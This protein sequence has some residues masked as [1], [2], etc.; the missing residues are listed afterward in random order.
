MPTRYTFRALLSIVV[1]LSTLSAGRGSPE[2]DPRAI[3][4]A[5]RIQKYVDDETLAGAVMAVSEGEKILAL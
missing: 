5:C 2:R 4:L 1:C 3:E